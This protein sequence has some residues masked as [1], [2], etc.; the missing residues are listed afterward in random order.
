[1]KDTLLEILGTFGVIIYFVIMIALNLAWTVLP[2]Y[3]AFKY[4]L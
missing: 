3:I 1:M 4:F 2:V